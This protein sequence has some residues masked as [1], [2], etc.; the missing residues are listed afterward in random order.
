MLDWPASRVA[1]LLELRVVGGQIAE[2]T[3]F[4]AQLFAAFGLEETL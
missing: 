1:E 4:G 2:I 3:T